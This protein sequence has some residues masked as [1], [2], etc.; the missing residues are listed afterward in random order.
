MSTSTSLSVPNN[1]CNNQNL[2]LFDLSAFKFLETISIKRDNFKHVSSFIIDGL[3][4]L[5]SIEIGGN[6]FT[7]FTNSCGNNPGKSCHIRNCKELKSILF[8]A[9]TFIDYSAG[10]ELSNLP[11][12]ESLKIGEH[13]VNVYSGCFC[14]SNFYLR[15]KM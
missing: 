7:E 13:W 6:A 11:K 1:A 4:K 15:S 3:F 9:A 8:E 5:R 10:L 2:T 14:S 12:L